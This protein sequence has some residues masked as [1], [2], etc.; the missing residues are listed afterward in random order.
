MAYKYIKV[1]VLVCIINMSACAMHPEWDTERDNLFTLMLGCRNFKH[2]NYTYCTLCQEMFSTIHDA[3]NEDGVTR[4]QELGGGAEDFLRMRH[5][6]DQ[7]K[8]GLLKGFPPV[9]N[10]LVK[11]TIPKKPEACISKKGVI[12]AWLVLEGLHV[13]K[14]LRYKI[15]SYLPEALYVY[16]KL[17]AELTNFDVKYPVVLRTNPKTGNTLLHTAAATNSSLA[18][19]QLIEKGAAL[20][21]PNK[22]GYTPLHY[23]ILY[24]AYPAAT[25]LLAK[26]A[27]PWQPDATGILPLQIPQHDITRQGIRLAQFQ[28]LP[29]LKNI[30]GSS[31]SDSVMG[32]DYDF[33]SRVARLRQALTLPQAVVAHAN[34]YL[35]EALRGDLSISGARV[36]ADEAV[37][38]LTQNAQENRAVFFKSTQYALPARPEVIAQLPLFLQQKVAVLD[39]VDKDALVKA[40]VERHCSMIMDMLLVERAINLDDDKVRYIDNDAVN[41]FGRQGC[42][43]RDY[44]LR[45]AVPELHTLLEPD[46]EKVKTDFKEDIRASYTKL[47]AQPLCDVDDFS[48]IQVTIVSQEDDALRQV[49]GAIA[50]RKY[51]EML[52]KQE[53]NE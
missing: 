3:V 9:F 7:E 47:F 36:Q 32:F 15:F 46:I 26:G 48:E 24:K 30:I 11:H 6:T 35:E 51:Q 39:G 27:D 38:F 49:I 12:T 5:R 18:L 10:Y 41:F 33:D 16:P 21:V 17:S 8:A 25:Q 31:L 44:A 37:L 4:L 13:S 40:N 28:L 43:L 45:S 53:G 19:S 52:E 14:D 22:K 1:L 50:H 2:K 34:V 42:S 23:A 20:N 29:L